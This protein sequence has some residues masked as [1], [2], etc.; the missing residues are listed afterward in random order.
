MKLSNGCFHILFLCLSLSHSSLSHSTCICDM[1][2][3]LSLPL[4]VVVFLW[5][6]HFLL[7]LNGVFRGSLTP[8]C[9]VFSISCV[10]LVKSY[11]RRSLSRVFCFCKIL[12]SL[13]TLT[14]VGAIW[15]KTP[16]CVCKRY[17]GSL[18]MILFHDRF[19]PQVL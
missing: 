18:V 14:A 2:S 16:A 3:L 4:K 13:R 1:D 17:N 6:L 12:P 8:H 10:Y 15:S 9:S 7:L 19:W 5:F 11:Q